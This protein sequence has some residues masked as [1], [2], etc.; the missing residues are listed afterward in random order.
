MVKS[1]SIGEEERAY[2]EKLKSDRNAK[3]NTKSHKHKKRGSQKVHV[4]YF[5]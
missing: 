2:W 3:H 5:L 4:R 1:L